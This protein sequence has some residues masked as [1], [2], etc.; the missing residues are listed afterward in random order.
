MSSVLS[1]PATI[2]ATNEATF[3]PGFARLS[4]GTMRCC[5]DSS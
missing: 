2:P 1:A 4:V 3:N 5:W